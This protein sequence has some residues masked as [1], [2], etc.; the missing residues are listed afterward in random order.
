MFTN[1]RRTA[2]WMC[3][4]WMRGCPQEP[5]SGYRHRRP[6]E[7]HTHTPMANTQNRKGR[8]NRLTNATMGT[9]RLCQ[10]NAGLGHRLTQSVGRI[11]VVAGLIL[12]VPLRRDVRI[13]LRRSGARSTSMWKAKRK[14]ST[15]A[16]I[17]RPTFSNSPPMSTLK[18]QLSTSRASTFVS[19]PVARGRLATAQRT[20]V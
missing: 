12:D 4:A 9:T 14:G 8:K 1:I 5:L 10:L 18:S 15:T 11:R 13:T 2:V 19:A 17:V 3:P 7:E 20:E 16:S 6:D